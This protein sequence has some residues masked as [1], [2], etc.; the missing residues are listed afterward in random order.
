MSRNPI[1]RFA[2]WLG[3]SEDQYLSAL[4]YVPLVAAFVAGVVL[5]YTSLVDLAEWLGFGRFERPFFPVAIDALVAGCY[6]AQARLAG[7][8]GFGAHRLYI[9]ILGGLAALLTGSGN[10]LHGLIVWKV[11]ALP[12]PWPVLTTGSLVPALAMAGVGHALAICRA[13][14]RQRERQS[15]AQSGAQLSVTAPVSGALGD[16]HSDAQATVT[17]GPAL[18]AGRASGGAQGDAQRALTEAVTEPAGVTFTPARRTTR[19]NQQLRRAALLIS[20]QPDITQAE[21]AKRL[22]VSAATAGRVM[23]DLAAESPFRSGPGRTGQEVAA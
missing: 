7:V 20:Q 14:A 11:V 23:R 17:P 6:I 4:G 3:W 13:A 19:K 9:V 16:A 12:L 1:A 18:T 15:D 2:R 8:K 22:R 10:A 21:L 5:S